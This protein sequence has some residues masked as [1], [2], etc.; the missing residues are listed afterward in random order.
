MHIIGITGQSGC[1]KGFLSTALKSLGF[2]H[3]D[4]DRIYHDLLNT[5]V[6]LRNE[7]VR[8]F[9]SD[10]ENNGII[11]RK[12]LGKKV[13]GKSNARKLERLNKIAHKYVCREYIKLI[14]SLKE[15]KAKGLIIDAP[16]LIEARLDKLCD[17]N[18]LVACSK[19]TQINRIVAR[20]GITK[21]AAELRLSSQKPLTFY[22][23]HCDL[24]FISE[25]QGW[26]QE[27]LETIKNHL[28]GD[29]KN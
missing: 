4:A 7:L 28:Y 9:G 25:N 11:D 2:V 29:F 10:I 24:V 17:L 27:A 8:T 23:K 1:G 20:D 18:I 5:S 19:D 21:D 6:P 3:A 16:L 12:V 22:A 26:E 13:L 15:E 14:I